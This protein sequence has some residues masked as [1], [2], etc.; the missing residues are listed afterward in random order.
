MQRPLPTLAAGVF[1]IA[2]ALPTAARAADDGRAKTA[3]PKAEGHDEATVSVGA[4]SEAET[5]GDVRQGKATDRG[6]LRWIERW[7]PERNMIELGLY[8]GLFFADEDHDLYDPITAPQDPLWLASPDIG[9]R[10]GYFPLRPLGI[11]AEFSANPT[12]VRTI[13]DDFAFV[14]GFRGH[15]VAQ[16]PFYSVVPFLLGGYGLLGVKSN[17]L[18]LG[19]DVDPAFHYGAGVKVY[20]NRW[21]SAR[22]EFRNIVSAAEARQ[23]SGTLHWQALLGVAVTLGRS[24]AKPKPPPKPPPDPDRDKDGILNEQDDC[25]DTPGLEPHGCPDTDGDGFRDSQDACPEVPGVAPDGCPVKDTDGDGIMDP[26]D[27]CV[28]QPETYNGHE[29]ED[30]CPDVVPEKIKEF[31]GTIEGIEFE[32]NKATI[33]PSSKPKL[34]EAIEVLDEFPAVEI[35]ITGHTDDVGTPEFNQKLSEERAA[36][37]KKYLV[38]GGID[39]SRITTE[40]RGSSEPVASNETEEGRAQNRRIEFEIVTRRPP[41]AKDSVEDE[42]RD[43]ATPADGDGKLE[44]AGESDAPAAESDEGGSDKGGKT[45][46]KKSERASKPGGAKSGAGDP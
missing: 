6:E 25:P 31:T 46:R 26:D 34:D 13:T 36:A 21:V 32:F 35:E 30:G 18:I 3:E 12:R 40:G 4:G 28:F 27:D 20:F 43:D 22:A 11:E 41:G 33:R 38:D 29:D 44:A 17:V 37:V 16:L 39:P 10:A 23:N 1:S 42:A 9:I 19:D 5:G 24:K 15:V 2:V 8:G 45:G 14:Y 7:R